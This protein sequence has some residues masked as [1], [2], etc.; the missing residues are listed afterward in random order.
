MTGSQRRLSSKSE[1]K[2]LLRHLVL[3]KMDRFS[4][5]TAVAWAALFSN[6]P[7]IP[8]TSTVANFVP[9]VSVGFG[10]GK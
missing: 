1:L 4:Y 2:Y 10:N 8:T 7:K 9:G 3:R 6:K 5:K